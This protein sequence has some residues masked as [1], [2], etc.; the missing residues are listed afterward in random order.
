[1]HGRAAAPMLARRPVI[2]RPDHAIVQRAD[3]MCCMQAL[4][5]EFAAAAHQMLL[6]TRHI[7][8]ISVLIVEPGQ[9]RAELIC[10]V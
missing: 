9:Q 2:Q 7:R 1:M 8:N 4:V 10:Q 5:H 6:F 3:A